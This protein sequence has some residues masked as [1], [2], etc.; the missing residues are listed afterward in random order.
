[1]EFA[2]DALRRYEVEVGAPAAAA[3]ARRERA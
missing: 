2:W 3:A 1:V